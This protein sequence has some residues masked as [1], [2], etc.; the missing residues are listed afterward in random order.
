MGE[1][2]RRS[3]ILQ[4]RVELSGVVPL[5]WRRLLI[6]S[7]YT[8]MEL[9]AVL[10]GAMGWED[11]H[12]YMF[13]LDDASYEQ[14]YDGEAPVADGARDAAQRVVGED[15][16]RGCVLHYDYDFGDGWH[17][18]V[19]VEDENPLSRS[20][21]IRWPWCVAGENA[22]PPEDCGGP[23][24]FQH[25]LD[26]LADPAHEEFERLSNWAQGYVA[27]EFNTTQANKLIQAVCSI[28]RSTYGCEFPAPVFPEIE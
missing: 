16:S 2:K 6:P 10:Q 20:D 28:Y 25:L 15:L 18:L 9:H 19:H 14:I 21:Q 24:G 27:T 1:K 12:L 3:Q 26:V 5:V 13:R 23:Y 8:F 11:A 7:G 22:C 17:H 4:V